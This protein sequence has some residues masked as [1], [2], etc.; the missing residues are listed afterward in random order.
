MLSTMS[1]NPQ[2][3]LRSIKIDLELSYYQ[4]EHPDLRGI[5]DGAEMRLGALERLVWNGDRDLFSFELRFR[6]LTRP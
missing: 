4:D 5:Q 2:S 6:K 1:D 3:V